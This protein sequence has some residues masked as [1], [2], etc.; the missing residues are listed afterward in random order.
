MLTSC[1]YSETKTVKSVGLIGLLWNTITI[2]KVLC[3]GKTFLAA[4]SVFSVTW[5]FLILNNL[6]MLIWSSRNI[7]DQ[8]F[9]QYFSISIILNISLYYNFGETIIPFIVDWLIDWLSDE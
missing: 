9:K 4:I 7:F 3:G 8:S 6:N 5:F 2:E 1:I